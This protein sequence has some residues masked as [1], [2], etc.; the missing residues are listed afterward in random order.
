M[1]DRQQSLLC[2]DIPNGRVRRPDPTTGSE[3]SSVWASRSMAAARATPGGCRSRAGHPARIR[4]WYTFSLPVGGARPRSCLPTRRGLARCPARTPGIA[5]GPCSG[6]RSPSPGDLIKRGARPGDREEQLRISTAAC[7]EGDSHNTPGHRRYQVC[8][9]VGELAG[10]D[11]R[12]DRP[13]RVDARATDRP[14][15]HDGRGERGAD[16]H[17]GGAP[18]DPGVGGDRHDHQDQHEGDNGFSREHPSRPDPGGRDRGAQAGDGPGLV[19]VQ[20][21][22]DGGRGGRAGELGEEIARGVG[23]GEAPA[24]S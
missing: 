15:D 23:P 11:H 3:N 1:G 5:A 22:G 14:A 13:G 10:Q 16:G 12:P 9:P 18:R 7:V 19:P 4:S 17:R 6:R 21:P 24:D 8:P 20:A 2:L